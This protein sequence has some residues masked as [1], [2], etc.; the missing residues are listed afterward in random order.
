MKRMRAQDREVTL[1][2]YADEGSEGRVL[3]AYS[4]KATEDGRPRQWLGW[5]GGWG[6]A[7]SE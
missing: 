2:K 7:D 5:S 6:A 3:E 1:R 4:S